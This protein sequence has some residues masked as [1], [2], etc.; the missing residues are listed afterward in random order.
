VDSASSSSTSSTGVTLPGSMGVA[1]KLF[2]N[3]NNKNKSSTTA[4]ATAASE[5]VTDDTVTVLLVS[6]P[7][8]TGRSKLVQQLLQENKNLVPPNRIYRRDDGATFERLERR[9][10]FLDFGEGDDTNSILNEQ[11]ESGLIPDGIFEAAKGDD[12][13]TNKN[14]VVIDASIELAKRITESSSLP[15][16]RI[17]GVWIGLNSVS[18]FEYNIKQQLQEGTLVIPPDEYQ[19]EESFLRAKIKEIISE[20]DYGLGS[21]IFEFTILNSINDNKNDSDSD[22]TTTTTKSSLSELKEAASYAFK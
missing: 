20:I 10:E 11:R 5:T 8:A 17:I 21:G 4:V 13:V 2:S 12:A 9:N 3:S 1:A 15:N 18:D 6:G 22:T 14:V 16:V 19:N 7:Q